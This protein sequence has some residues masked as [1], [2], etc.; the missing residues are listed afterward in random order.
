MKPWLQMFNT[1]LFL[2]GSCGLGETLGSPFLQR[3][4]LPS[5]HTTCTHA[6]EPHLLLSTPSPLEHSTGWSWEFLDC[7]AQAS[8]VMG[9]VGDRAAGRERKAGSSLMAL[10]ARDKSCRPPWP[11]ASILSPRWGKCP[12]DVQHHPS[13]IPPSQHKGHT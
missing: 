8:L 5:T 13:L 6:R 12:P 9:W 11:L 10:D 7:N 4:S 2:E 1:L 3:D